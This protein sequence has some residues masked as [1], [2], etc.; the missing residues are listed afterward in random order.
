M[1]VYSAS[2][3]NDV[4]KIDALT[5]TE[6]NEMYD[7]L[8]RKVQLFHFEL[9]KEFRRTCELIG[10]KYILDSGTLLGAVRH[11]GFIPWDDDVDVGMLRKEYDVFLREAPEIL[12][13]GFYLR[14]PETDSD[15]GES[16]AKL[17]VASD[18]YLKNVEADLPFDC[19]GITLDVFPYDVFPVDQRKRRTQ[20]K[21]CDHYKKLLRRKTKYS[22]YV[23]PK[24]L[25][26]R[27]YYAVHFFCRRCE[28][29]FISRDEL[30]KRLR[31]A[32]TSYNGEPSGLVFE[33]GGARAFKYG[34]WVVPESCLRETTEL[35]FEGE[36]FSC[37]VDYDAYLKATFGDYMKLP[38][39][40]ERA[41]KHDA[42]NRIFG[43]V[44]NRQN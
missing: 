43:I 34:A 15:Y 35:T 13:E 27:I 4:A 19:S 7:D 16:Y 9:L 6:R 21:L 40:N 18:K 36:K 39:E 14:A 10:A 28:T 23:P 24:G 12:K 20:G 30:L 33:S 25:F 8:L 11:R 42:V 37:P 31:T 38:P 22:R 2:L 5:A 41:P 32:Q 17:C 44:K 26:Q 29:S 1:I 3:G